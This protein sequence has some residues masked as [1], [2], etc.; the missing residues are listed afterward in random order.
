MTYFGKNLC[1]NISVGCAE[2]SDTHAVYS[3]LTTFVFSLYCQFD[4]V[5]ITIR[6][7]NLPGERLNS[8]WAA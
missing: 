4:H 3:S 5:G 7:H 8:V 1:K 6:L 2:S